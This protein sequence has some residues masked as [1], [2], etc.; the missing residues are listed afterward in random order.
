[1]VGLN[2]NRACAA[3]RSKEPIRV[4]V[5]E[6]RGL[7]APDHEPQ[8]VREPGKPSCGGFELGFGLGLESESGLACGEFL[9]LLHPGLALGRDDAP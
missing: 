7:F 8:A 4:R 1:M 3:C 5:R 2:P 9:E 6:V